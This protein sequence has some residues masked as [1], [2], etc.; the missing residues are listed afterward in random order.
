LVLLAPELAARISIPNRSAYNFPKFSISSQKERRHS[1]AMSPFEIATTY[2]LA[3]I[4]PILSSPG[5]K[6]AGNPRV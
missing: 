4:A 6:L 1:L 5:R 3:G 2:F